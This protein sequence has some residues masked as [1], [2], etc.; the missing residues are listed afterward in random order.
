MNRFLRFYK[1]WSLPVGMAVG[2]IAYFVYAALPLSEEARSATHDAV[3]FIQPA[4]LFSML[5]LSFCKIDVS[6]LKPAP[7]D[8]WLLLFQCGFF[9]LMA[10]YLILFPQ[11]QW[12]IIIEGAMLAIICPT[13]TAAA[14]VTDKL[15]GS[16]AH[17]VSYTI[18]IN[19]CVSLLI[20]L[21]CPLI[22]PHESLGF[23]QAFLLMLGK[24][25]P[26]LICPLILA[27]VIRHLA[28]KLHRRILKAPNMAFYLWLVA[29]PLA[30]AVAVKCMV[31]G[32]VPVWFLATLAAVTGV[33]CFAQFYFGRKIGV[34]Y[35]DAISAG[36]ALGQKNTVFIIWLGYTF[37]TPI[38]ASVGG[39]YSIFHNAFNSWQL[40][41]KRIGKL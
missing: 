9:T 40:Y 25:F 6:D 8:K 19:L 26:M 18:L 35:D 4:L 3:G 37:F 29:L 24:V 28:P 14:V 7:W 10:L 38:T 2:I 23:V 11:N 21:L 36:Q 12:S 31:T 20:P 30:I 13:A 39:L 1:D 22:H 33:A 5:F 16:T 27:I 41:R 15:G 32:G 17:I 34:L